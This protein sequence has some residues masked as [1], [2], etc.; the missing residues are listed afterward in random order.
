MTVDAVATLG[1]GMVC[2][3]LNRDQLNAFLYLGSPE[4]PQPEYLPAEGRRLPQSD[5]GVRSVESVAS[6]L[7]LQYL[8]FSRNR[9]RAETR[10]H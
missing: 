1:R 4:T 3:V 5:P 10:S 6:L 2:V 8:S 7:V 9:G